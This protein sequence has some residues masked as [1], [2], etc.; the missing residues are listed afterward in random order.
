[1][2]LLTPDVFQTTERGMS[3]IFNSY[4]EKIKVWQFL[5]KECNLPVFA[6][7]QIKIQYDSIK[8]WAYDDADRTLK[9]TCE[10]DNADLIFD[11]L[12]RIIYSI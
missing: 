6:R 1:M 5:C 3:Y 4:K 7:R 11:F 8:F 9:F 12:R 2:E 10:K